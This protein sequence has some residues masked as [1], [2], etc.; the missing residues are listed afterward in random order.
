[1]TIILLMGFAFILLL[2]SCRALSEDAAIDF[3]AAQDIRE[4][5]VLAAKKIYKGALVGLT[6]SGYA[7]PFEPGDVFAGLAY[8]QKDSTSDATDGTKSVRVVTQGDFKFTLS[9]AALTDV[10]RPLYATADNTLA[11]TGHPDAFVGRVVNYLAS[12]TALVRLRAFGEAPPNGEGSITLALTGHEAFTATGATAGTAI[13][14]MFDFKTILGPGALMYDAEDAGL[15]LAFDAMAEIALASIRT[16]NDCLPVDKGLTFEL[17][18]SVTDNGDATAVDLDIGFGTALTTNS[19]ADIDHADMVQL[20]A[21]H[22][23]GNDENID[24]QSDDDTTDVP[25]TDTTIDNVAGTFKHLK[26]IVRPNGA[27]EGWI[28]GVRV[29][30]T[31]SFAMLSTALAAFFIN[32]EKTSDDTVYEVIIRNL[33]VK[34]GMS[35]V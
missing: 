3:A 28:N 30:S 17:D 9:G 24:L 31:T 26:G 34:A 29:L 10:N 11:T 1:M 14:G 16:R 22:F 32:V 33:L 19:E 4:Y 7:K 23:D 2:A 18:V 27:C 5:G 15:Q 35:Q 6:P 21:F 25:A 13:L 8:E 12:N 20:F